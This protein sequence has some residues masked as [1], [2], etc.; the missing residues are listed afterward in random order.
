VSLYALSLLIVS[1]ISAALGVSVYYRNKREASNKLFFI[2]AIAVAFI[3]FT[4]FMGAESFDYS[5]AHFWFR[6]GF[7][8]PFAQTILYL[9]ILAITGTYAVFI[10]KIILILSFILSLVVSVMH[11][12]TNRGFCGVYEIGLFLAF[13]ASLESIY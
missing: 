10:N 7:L 13:C 2:C 9:F 8:W 5:T 11:L 1:I 4:A 12:V 3:S 6:V